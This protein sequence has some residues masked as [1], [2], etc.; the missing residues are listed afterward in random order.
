MEGI[1]NIIFDLGGVLTGLDGQRCIDAFDAIGCE[2]VSYYVK[3]HLTQD[4]FYD[5]E[6][7]NI[8]TVGF[9]DEVRRMTGKNVF[10]EQIVWAWNQLLTGI[11][12]ERLERLLLLRNKYRLFLLSNTNDMHWQLCKDE[13]FTY[14][15]HRIEDFFD[16]TFVSYEMH[17]AKPNKE[18][19]AEVLRQANIRPAETLFIDD[20]QLNLDGAVSL[21]I[22]GYW[23]AHID[24][25]LALDL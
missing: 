1:K 8:T 14:R 12:E 20:S 6:I 24:D 10:D 16:H 13:F 23:N 9:C 21:D 4:L 5:I 7:G 3:Y 25:W 15:G 19:F 2:K 18:I 22:Q 11:S 17:L